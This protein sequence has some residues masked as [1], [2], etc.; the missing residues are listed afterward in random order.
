MPPVGRP[1]PDEA[2]YAA[3]VTL[4]ETKLDATAMAAPDPG[5]PPVH[6][7]NRTEYGNA[8]RDLLG[9]DIDVRRLLPA[10]DQA[11]GF[12]NLADVL[13][14]SPT[15]MERYLSAA[16]RISQLA[17]GASTVRPTFEMYRISANRA[18]D[19]RNSDD[20]PFGSRG[21]VSVRH[22]FPMDGEYLVRPRLQRTYVGYIRGIGQRHELDVRVDRER[23]ATLVV[24]G[25]DHGRPAP[26]SFAGEIFGDE[27]W[28]DYLHRA[29]ER[30]E[31][32]FA[33]KAGWRVVSLAFAKARALPEGPLQPIDRSSFNYGVD[34]MPYG[35]PAIESVAI[36]GPYVP[37]GQGDTPSRR[38]IF[39]CRP[40]SSSP[41]DERACAT[42]ILSTIARRAY[43]RPVD[44]ADVEILLDFY[45][46]RPSRRR[47]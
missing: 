28:E 6:R 31:V 44:S 47:L 9:L 46:D 5:R 17:V 37:S 16:R 35:D 38:R 13:S 34:E 4:L 27:D 10:D 12:D 33:A 29:D 39:V 41:A 2:S 7:L 21:G 36:G 1:R 22:Y 43:R 23:I 15:L 3:L 42:T 8:V 30:L 11:H 45:G 20:L 40:A 32:R 14:V 26:P 24:G 19:H 18:Q 25:E